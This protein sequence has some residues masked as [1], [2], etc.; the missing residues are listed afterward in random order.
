MMGRGI[1]V[2]A[3]LMVLVQAC[4]GAGQGARAAAGLPPSAPD[5]ILRGSRADSGTVVGVGAVSGI[6]NEALARDTAA[7]RGRA[8]IS[9]IMETYSA[10]LMKDYQEAVTAGNAPS[11]ESQMVTQAIKTYSANLING[12]EPTDYWFDASRKTWY[13]RV[14][15]D[16]AKAAEARAALAQMS[17]GLRKW[18]EDNQDRVLEEL[19]GASP[20]VAAA[21]AAPSEQDGMAPAAD[22]AP[23]REAPARV[24]GAAPGW[25]QGQCDRGR[26]LCGV[27]DGQTRRAADNDARAEISRIFSARIQSVVESFE[28]A[29]RSISNRTGEQWSEIQQVSQ[30]SMVSSDKALAMT[31]IRER[32]DDGKGTIW[33]LAVI[34][35]APATAALRAK[36]AELEGQIQAKVGMARGSDDR[37]RAWRS[38]RA[39]LGLMAQRAAAESDLRVISGAGYGQGLMGLAEVTALFDAARDDLAVG[40]AVSG[41]GAERVRECLE[42]AFGDR[43]YRLDAKI[44][45]DDEDVSISGAFDLVIQG[46]VRAESRGRVAGSEVVK[47][48]LSLKLINGKSG[49]VFKTLRGSDKGSRRSLAAA[50]STSAHKLCRRQVPKMVA[51]IDRHFAR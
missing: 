16:F 39:A 44:S 5:W 42:E 15:L 3:A 19:G 18:V 2:S 46:R 45:E 21:P 35:R 30:H 7:N 47:T 27:G 10:S 43:G 28:G 36:I 11:A 20:P 4:A 1:G 22:T 14:V 9:K 41:V 24:G 8:E 32:W 23:V 34:E 26:Y 25:T 6:K 37:V 48:S 12:A 17:P 38:L 50:A 40:L 13:C 33:S 49:R 31:E 51:A 29:S